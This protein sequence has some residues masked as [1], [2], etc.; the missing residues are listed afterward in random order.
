LIWLQ[1]TKAKEEQPGEKKLLNTKLQKEREPT[2]S[3]K[4]SLSYAL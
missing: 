2:D 1:K 3:D 4:Q